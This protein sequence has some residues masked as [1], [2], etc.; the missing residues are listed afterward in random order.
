MKSIS[1]ASVFA[2]IE[3][4]SSAKVNWV[5]E[6]RARVERIAK[7]GNFIFSFLF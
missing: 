5:E 4:V 7:V 6:R 1:L 2:E 3:A